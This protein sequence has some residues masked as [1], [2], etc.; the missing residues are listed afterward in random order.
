MRFLQE[1]WFLTRLD[2]RMSSSLLQHGDMGANISD[3]AAHRNSFRIGDV[4]VVLRGMS[5]RDVAFDDRLARFQADAVSGEVEIR[6][7]WVDDIQPFNGPVLFDSGSVWKVFEDGAGLV[8]DFTTPALGANPYRRL[9]ITRDFDSGDLLLNR[10][11]LSGR[12]EAVLPL[13]YP[14]DELLMVHR[15]TRVGGI[16]LHG[17]GVV[18]AERGGYLFLGHSGAGKST[19]MRLWKSLRN[20]KVLSDDRIVLRERDGEIWMYGTPWHGEPGLDDQGKSRING[21][22]VLEHGSANE[23]TPL[24][25]R[26]AVAELFARSFV[27]FYDR[28]Y[29]T[30]PL[31]FLH[32][33]TELLPCFRYH[34]VP[35]A[36]ALEKVVNP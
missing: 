31:K 6:V 17:C 27:P 12:G 8:F 25:P 28:E 33:V 4:S 10:E 5:E 24:S 15:L 2:K 32:E 21:I 7:T 36:S 23:L 29:L 14:L 9:Q 20:V 11:L 16:E 35:D 30:A 3:V 1:P 19:M 26:D 18:D 34:F 22:F 13:E